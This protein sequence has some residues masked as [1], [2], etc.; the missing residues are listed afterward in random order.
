MRKNRA[1]YIADWRMTKINRRASI[2]ACHVYR[3]S[4]DSEWNMDL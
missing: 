1:R 3:K 4:I 2:L